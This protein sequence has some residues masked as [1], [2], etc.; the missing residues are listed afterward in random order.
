MIGLL[1]KVNRHVMYLLI[2]VTATFSVV[3]DLLKVSVATAY[4]SGMA[5]STLVVAAAILSVL[6][7]SLFARLLVRVSF[8]ICGAI[9]TR[10]NG[11]FSPFPIGFTDYE[12]TA[13]A[14]ALP[15]FL[16]G[17]VL[18]LPALF[19]P[20]LSEVLDPLRTLTNWSFLALG[21]AYG[22]K[23]YGHDYDRKSLAIS[24]S[25][26]PLVLVGLSLFLLISEVVR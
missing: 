3:K 23:R 21:A 19:L 24:L 18:V 2:G 9:F 7:F 15:C 16:L 12:S 25:V 11:M 17:G 5:P 14:F 6:I 22:V 4:V 26:I 20:T 10:S 1:R 13:L 8:R